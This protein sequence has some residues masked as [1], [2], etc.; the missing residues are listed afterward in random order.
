[1]PGLFGAPVLFVYV[2]FSTPLYYD[3]S[4]IKIPKKEKKSKIKGSII[5]LLRNFS[6]DYLNIINLYKIMYA[7]CNKIF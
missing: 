2:G 7:D 4:E 3:Q 6:K 1:M 5:T